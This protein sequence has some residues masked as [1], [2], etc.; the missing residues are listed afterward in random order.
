MLVGVDVVVPV[1]VGVKVDV[2]VGV[3]VIVA[4]GE[5]VGVG[6]TLGVMDGVNVA[7]GTPKRTMRGATQ[8]GSSSRA[9]PLVDATKMNFPVCPANPLKS[10]SIV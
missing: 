8:M 1:D 10:R 2:P 5:A 4:V 6:V 7:G 9:D 3:N